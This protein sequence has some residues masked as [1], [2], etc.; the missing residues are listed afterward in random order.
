MVTP[1]MSNEG[2]E[3]SNDSDN[4]GPDAMYDKPTKQRKTG[5]RL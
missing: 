2:D 4:E 3:N 5:G 1:Q